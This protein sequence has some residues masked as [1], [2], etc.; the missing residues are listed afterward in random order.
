MLSIEKIAS[1]QVELLTSTS[2]FNKQQSCIVLE[3]S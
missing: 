2:N 1:I 3:A